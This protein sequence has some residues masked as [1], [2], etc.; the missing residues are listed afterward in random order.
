MPPAEATS[1]VCRF[2][3]AQMLSRTL[4]RPIGFW[5][6]PSANSMTRVSMRSPAFGFATVAK[7]PKVFGTVPDTENTF[8]EPICPVKTY[9]MVVT[10][11]Y[12]STET[13]L[14]SEPPAVT[15]TCPLAAPPADAKNKMDGAGLPKPVRAYQPPAEARTVIPDSV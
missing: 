8:V 6:T 11:E 10:L 12:R 1:P 9:G 5:A 3:V 15:L 4:S 14:N 7:F 13:N 2:P